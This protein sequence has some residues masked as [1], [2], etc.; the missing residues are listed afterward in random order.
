MTE[1][2]FR[3]TDREIL[4]R[5]TPPSHRFAELSRGES[6]FPSVAVTDDLNFVGVDVL[7][8]PLT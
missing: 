5:S 4:N 7:G 2:V 1:R 3:L 8:D 6:L